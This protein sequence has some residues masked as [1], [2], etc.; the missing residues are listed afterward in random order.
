MATTEAFES[1]EK[2]LDSV[3]IAAD[4]KS[5]EVYFSCKEISRENHHVFLSVK[6]LREVDHILDFF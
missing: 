5:D 4:H 2:F 1:E 6:L 3:Q